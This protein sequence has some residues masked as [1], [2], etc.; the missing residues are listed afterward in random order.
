MPIYEYLCQQCS[1]RFQVLVRGA[2]TPSCPSCTSTELE[3]QFSVFA[4]GGKHQRL[5]D[6][7]GPAPCGTCGDPRGPGA[8]TLD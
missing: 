4:V 5:A 1:H 3:L 7:Q 2:T 8:C 6:R